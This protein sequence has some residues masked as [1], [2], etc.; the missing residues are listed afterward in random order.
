[1]LRGETRNADV[2]ILYDPRRPAEKRFAMAW[3]RAIRA[4][5]R[6]LRVRRNYPYLGV[7][8]GLTTTLRRRF[9][10]WR[11]LGIELEVNQRFFVTDAGAGAKG[12]ESGVSRG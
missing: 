12:P 3:A 2:G 7:G 11:Y 10:A 8:D 5:A 6:E 4:A 9:P 1:M